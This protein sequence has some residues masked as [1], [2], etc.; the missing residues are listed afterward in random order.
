MD[1]IL[2]VRA[3]NLSSQEILE[4]VNFFLEEN[5]FHQ[6]ATI[7]P[8]FILRAQK[9]QEFMN[10]LNVCDLNVADGMGINFAFWRQCKK[11]KQ[12]QKIDWRCCARRRG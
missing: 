2:G 9:D 4:K 11:L 5:K 10:V 7:N 12:H 3:D 1:K 8:E 6:I